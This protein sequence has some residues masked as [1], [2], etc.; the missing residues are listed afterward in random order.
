[1][2]CG[3][4]FTVT[5]KMPPF[6]VVNKCSEK[7][8]L[9]DDCQCKVCDCS[10]LEKRL[11]KP[12]FIPKTK[13]AAFSSTATVKQPLTVQTVT[14]RAPS[15][16][17]HTCPRC[18]TTWDHAANPGHNCPNCGTAQYTQDRSPR[19]VTVRAAAK[20]PDAVAP[21]TLA[22]LQNSVISSSACANGQCSTVTTSRRGFVRR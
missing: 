11:E 14:T 19:P 13:M 21:L 22:Q 6:T 9:C 7:C 10:V 8:S 12:P 18:G 15:G 4:T 16:H 20:T 1:M 2:L 5:N 17:T 3:E